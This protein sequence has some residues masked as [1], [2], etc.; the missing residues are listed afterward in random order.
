M[1]CTLV[2]GKKIFFYTSILSVWYIASI[3]PSVDCSLIDF[4]SKFFKVSEQNAYPN[5]HSAHCF[6]TEPLTI[7][8]AVYEGVIPSTMKGCM[9]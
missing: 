3:D 2:V 5:V 4:D 8:T 1:M 9:N 6:C 7:L